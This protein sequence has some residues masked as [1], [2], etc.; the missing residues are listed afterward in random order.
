MS[1]RGPFAAIVAVVLSAGL[2]A[3]L[4]PASDAPRAATFATFERDNSLT[5]VS[6]PS[7]GEVKVFPDEQRA[8]WTHCC[9]G[10]GW[11]VAYDW[12]VPTILL[13]DDQA[14]VELGMQVSNVNPEQRLFFQM[15]MLAPDKTDALNF[16]YPDKTSDKKVAQFPISASYESSDTLTITIR[17]I[18]G[19]EIRYVYKRASQFTAC[20]GSGASAY[21]AADCDKLPFGSEFTLK[22]PGEKS[23]VDVSPKKTPGT[24]EEVFA[25]FREF[26]LARAEEEEQKRNDIIATTTL[27][28]EQDPELERLVSICVLLGIDLINEKSVPRFGSATALTEACRRLLIKNTS[29]GRIA[30]H[31]AANGCEAVF[32]PAFRKGEKVTKRMRRRAVA[33]A[34]RQLNVSCTSRAGRL[35]A[36]IKARH[37]KKLRE[38]T[39]P[40]LR[41]FVG[42]RLTQ[43]SVE[44]H[45]LAVRWSAR[46]R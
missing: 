19:A 14:E 10:G 44:E 38:V 12:T 5:T 40:R 33:A 1:R 24:A 22:A 4:V 35:S 28:V 25:A 27:A 37:G 18:G 42:R 41:T 31:A 32:V 17:E 39:Q 13:T 23:P 45:R 26:V 7:P 15:S 30:A 2:G 34:R 6:N 21:V 3:I 46:N 29:S 8:V 20:T 36:S 11:T 16:T 43:G 9:T